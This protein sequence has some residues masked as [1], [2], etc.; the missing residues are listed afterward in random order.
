MKNK[1]RVREGRFRAD[2]FCRLAVLRLALPPLRER[3]S[4]FRRTTKN[5]T[6]STA[7]GVIHASAMC[8]PRCLLKISANSHGRPK[9]SVSSVDSTL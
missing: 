1:Q 8:R 7:N 3:P 4:V 6:G 5:L 2:L 9:T